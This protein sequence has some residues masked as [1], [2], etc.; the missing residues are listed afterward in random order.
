MLDNFYTASSGSQGNKAHLQS[1]KN[2]LTMASTLILL[3]Q[4]KITAER[5]FKDLLLITFAL[6]IVKENKGHL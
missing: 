3:E 4:E 2:M 6:L 1:Q 5:Q